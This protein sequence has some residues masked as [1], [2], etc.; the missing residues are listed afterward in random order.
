[1]RLQHT[2]FPF[3]TE[4]LLL[5]VALVQGLGLGLAGCSG[6]SDLAAVAADAA[7]SSTAWQAQL[8]VTPADAVRNLSDGEGELVMASAIAA[9]EQ[10]RP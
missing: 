6:P 5:L 1:M 3:P 9:H 10:R 8:S 2:R 4:R 7:R